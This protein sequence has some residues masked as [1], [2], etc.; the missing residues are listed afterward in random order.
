[1]RHTQR[2]QP[3]GGPGPDNLSL[4]SCAVSVEPATGSGAHARH[5]DSEP[6]A[7]SAAA[8]CVSPSDTQNLNTNTLPASATS[9]AGGAP[10]PA[11]G[12]G[13]QGTGGGG[14]VGGSS[15][16]QQ[17]PTSPA[18]TPTR[19][20]DTLMGGEPL[21][22][23]DEQG[24]TRFYPVFVKSDGTQCPVSGE[25]LR[26]MGIQWPPPAPVH[27]RQDLESIASELYQQ[28]LGNQ[29]PANRSTSAASASPSAPH[30]S[31]T[32]GIDSVAAAALAQAGLREVSHA[33]LNGRAGGS[34]SG[35][36]DLGPPFSPRSRQSRTGGLAVS[37]VHQPFS[38]ATVAGSRGDHREGGA[39]D[40]GPGPSN[41]RGGNL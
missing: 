38:E 21:T 13:S 14:L 4:P 1:M 5:A 26:A 10:Q 6:G 19:N 15:T 24:N 23:T 11:A 32:G 36:Q 22:E 35:V 39:P 41:S 31:S 33:G 34:P 18:G 37:S 25:Y 2:V 9:A 29:P 30:H 20:M 7:E 3:R 27:I 28:A 8:H 17:L 12:R 40:S 16:P